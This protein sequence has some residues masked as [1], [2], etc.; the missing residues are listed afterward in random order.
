MTHA[1]QISTA[2]QH[3]IAGLQHHVRCYMGQHHQ[4][5]TRAHTL[6]C[7]PQDRVRTTGHPLLTTC[8]CTAQLLATACAGR[9][10]QGYSRKGS[11]QEEAR[12]V[13]LPSV[14]A[15]CRSATLP[16]TKLSSI[17]SAVG[18]YGQDTM[19][20]PEVTQQSAMPAERSTTLWQK[21]GVRMWL[22]HSQVYRPILHM[23][24][25][26]PTKGIWHGQHSSSRQTIYVAGTTGSEV[27]A[28]VND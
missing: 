23:H 1:L 18:P 28:A 12:I 5:H 11:T 24:G 25:K 14:S 6:Q 27:G 3:S 4:P 15:R 10:S 26:T 9:A 21:H 13:R 16:T 19:Q 8:Y 7:G 20:W 2:L 22:K 17:A